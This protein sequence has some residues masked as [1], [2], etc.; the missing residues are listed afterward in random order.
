MKSIGAALVATFLSTA[1]SAHDHHMDKIEDGH[2]ISDDP[3]VR[4]SK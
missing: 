3:I 4:E 1:V 2:A